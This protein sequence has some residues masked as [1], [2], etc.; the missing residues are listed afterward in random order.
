MLFFAF[1]WKLNAKKL[2][3]LE[4]LLSIINSRKARHD[5]RGQIQIRRYILH[6]LIS[7][8]VRIIKLHGSISWWN[9]GGS[10]VVQPVNIT[11]HHPE[12]WRNNKS[13]IIKDIR[14]VPSFLTGVSKVF[15]YNRGI[16]AD[17]NYRF[18]QLLHSEDLMV[19]SGYGWGDL[20]INFQLQNWL[21]REEKS[22]MILLHRD[23]TYLAENS[24]EL[25]HVYDKYTK[26][27]Q[28]I[29]LKKWLSET[30]LAEIDGYW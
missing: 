21:A 3:Y 29:P 19:M 7:T 22:T 10:H 5:T 9:Q 13:E 11:D 12:N 20:P 8:L 25:R 30:S 26:N 17:Q 16:Y 2:P 15:S 14:P 28:I 6:F 27:R 4:L 23:P 24:L 18:L 1:L